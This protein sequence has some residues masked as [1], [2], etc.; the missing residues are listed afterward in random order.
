MTADGIRIERWLDTP[1]KERA[2][3]DV[4]AIFFDSSGTKTFASDTVRTA[5]RER[6]LGRYFRFDPQWAY[7]ARS[8]GGEVVG[9]LVGCLDDPART[10]RFD[11]IP[12]LQD[13]KTLTPDYPAHLHVNCAALWR[14]KG[15][16][17]MLVERFAADA[18]AA[19]APGVHIVTGEGLRNVRFYERIGFV[20]KGS[21][22][23]NGKTVVLLGR[24]LAR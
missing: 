5:F 12:V 18:A 9:Y 2:S 19:G 20:L 6:W 1:D 3:R 17:A 7:L 24:D 14:S 13:F 21:A 15:V 8:A 23:F 4:D 10:A 11:D 22:T 16:G